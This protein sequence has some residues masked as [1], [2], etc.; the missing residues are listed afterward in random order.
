MRH[1]TPEQFIKRVKRN[2]AVAK[3]RVYIPKEKPLRITKTEN[4][5]VILVEWLCPLCKG[6]SG[7]KGCRTC[8]GHGS[9]DGI[10]KAIHHE[11]HCEH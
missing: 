7:W 3:R 9:I 1:E 8:K 4:G 10:T 5:Q 6:N 2:M 11:L